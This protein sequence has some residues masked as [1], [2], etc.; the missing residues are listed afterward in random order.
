MAIRARGLVFGLGNPFAGIGGGLDLQDIRV[1]GGERWVKIV[2][3]RWE[4]GRLLY[5]TLHLKY[6]CF[7]WLS[8]SS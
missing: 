6:I 3:I 7:F 4:P 2:A 5:S 8:P 1:G